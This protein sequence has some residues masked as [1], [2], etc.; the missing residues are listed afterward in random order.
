M[1]VIRDKFKLY[2]NDWSVMFEQ[3]F[4]NGMITVTLRSSSG[5]IHDK[6]RCDDYRN[7]MDYFRAFKSIAKN[8][9]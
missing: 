2:P 1:R 3:Q 6:V 4:H 9:H 8:Q 5:E 7:A